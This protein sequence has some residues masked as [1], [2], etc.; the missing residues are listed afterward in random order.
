MPDF[1]RIG[2][3]LRSEL[4]RFGPNAGLAAV[5]AAWPTA[6]GDSIARNAW[7]Q[8]INRDGTLHVATSGAAWAF[9]LTQLAGEIQERLRTALGE[10]APHTL[11]FTPGKLPAHGPDPDAG[12]PAP[13]PPATPE[14][15]AT[16][17]G[18]AA[19]IED[20]GLREAVARA[21]RASLVRG[22][23]NRTL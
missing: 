11:R 7:P 18:W 9:E 16:A 20:P 19:A 3:E 10:S 4:S 21:A 22:R 14:E 8:R 15:T 5:V 12:P 23:G 17:E 13:Q 2:E 6:V 1:D